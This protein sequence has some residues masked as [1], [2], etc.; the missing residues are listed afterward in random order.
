M[1]PMSRAS[2]GRP[3]RPRREIEAI[4]RLHRDSGLSLLAF[5]R[6]DRL[7]YPA[8]WGWRRRPDAMHAPTHDGSAGR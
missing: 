2:S 5:A 1:N 3:G 6:Q 8:L 4:L 7:P